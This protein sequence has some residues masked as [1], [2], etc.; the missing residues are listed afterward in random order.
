MTDFSKIKE[1]LSQIEEQA[2]E[3][4][5]IYMDLGNLFLRGEGIEHDINKAVEYFQKGSDAGIN[6]ASF[7]LAQIYHIGLGGNPIDIPKAV[8]LYEKCVLNDDLTAMFNL[9]MIYIVGNGVPKNIPRGIE[10]LETSA[11]KGFAHSIY[12]LAL[13]YLSGENVPYDCQK[14]IE[15]LETG[16]EKGYFNCT[17]RLAILYRDGYKEIPPD[18]GKCG[19]I[20]VESAKTKNPDAL[21]SLGEYY[22]YI[23]KNTSL[24]QRSVECYEEAILKN[25]TRSMYNLANL[26]V[27]TPGHF[28]PRNPKRSIELLTKASEL[29]DLNSMKKLAEIY[30]EKDPYKSLYYYEKGSELGDDDCTYNLA[31]MYQ[32]G[33]GIPKNKK[34]ALE[35][36]QKAA[37]NNHV[38]ALTNLGVMYHYGKGVEKDLNKA[39]EYYE[40]AAKKDI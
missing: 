24:I 36:Y 1:N 40:A 12:N 8:N 34:K 22:E 7:N 23:G 18:L 4:P 16:S 20:L 26:L 30:R 21:C 15:L 39:S 3:N 27:N 11:Q 31:L 17:I 6:D 5:Q 19:R 13:Q 32:E 38:Q 9:A 29:G 33:E 14:A 2:K 10:L 37:S 28:V 35:L 25:H